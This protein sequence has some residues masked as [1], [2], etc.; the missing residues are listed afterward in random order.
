M[1]ASTKARKANV[2]KGENG[3]ERNSTIRHKKS[4]NENLASPGD[5]NTLEQE[6][7]VKEEE[8]VKPTIE[9]LS[10]Q[11]QGQTNVKKEEDIGI[12]AE[13]DST[14]QSQ[15]GNSVV[16]VERSNARQSKTQTQVPFQTV[17]RNMK[18]KHSTSE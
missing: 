17:T 5:N 18:R 16:K 8:D 7:V 6:V 10:S 11:V 15:D 14:C 13:Q 1:L 9:T 2:K 3:A 4:R 12:K